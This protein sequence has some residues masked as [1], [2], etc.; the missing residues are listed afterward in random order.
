MPDGFSYGNEEIKGRR[1]IRGSEV[2][3]ETNACSIVVPRRST[4]KLRNGL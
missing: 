1:K 4:E 3:E 2:S